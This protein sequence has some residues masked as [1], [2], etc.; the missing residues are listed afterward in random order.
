VSFS[1][2]PQKNAANDAVFDTLADEQAAAWARF[3]AIEVDSCP[4]ERLWCKHWKSSQA[5]L[6]GLDVDHAASTA[7]QISGAVL[8]LMRSLPSL[9]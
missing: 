7:F 4:G 6:L 9:N 8:F 1:N 5:G 3:Y 2:D